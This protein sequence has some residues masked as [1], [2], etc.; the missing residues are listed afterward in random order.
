MADPNQ[1]PTAVWA[2]GIK[3][4]GWYMAR[5]IWNQS[6]ADHLVTMGYE[7]ERSIQKPLRKPAR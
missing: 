2:Y 4:P 7:V 6:Y 3:E 5:A 1:D